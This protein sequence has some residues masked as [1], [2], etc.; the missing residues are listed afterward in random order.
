MK[1]FISDDTVFTLHEYGLDVNRNEIYLVGSPEYSMMQEEPDEPGVEHLMASKF[2]KNLH[3]A[4]TN[5]VGAKGKLLPI[6]IHM[7]TCGGDWGEG[8]AIYDAIKACPH[9]ITI[10]NYTHARSMS[11]LIFQAAERRVMMP[12][13]F[14]MMHEGDMLLAGTEKQVESAFKFFSKPVR[15][16]MLEVYFNRAKNAPYFKKWTKGKIIELFRKRMNDKEE[17]Y[18]LPKDT[19][20]Y[21]LA[22]E[23]FTTWRNIYKIIRKKTGRNI[24]K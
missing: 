23:I 17:W 13:S 19:I 14:F 22:D 5:A 1:K 6:I 15:E 21:G 12:H 11:S 9:P 16:Q 8:M 20:K 4:M 24:R 7:K 18:L 2:I 3:V 10:I